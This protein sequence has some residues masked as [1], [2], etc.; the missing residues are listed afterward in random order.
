MTAR[1]IRPDRTRRPA[2]RKE[3]VDHEHHHADATVTI[4]LRAQVVGVE[5]RADQPPLGIYLFD[6][7]EHPLCHCTVLEDRT[8]VELPRRMLGRMVTAA[9]APVVAGRK[10]PTLDTLRTRGV[11]IVRVPLDSVRRGIDLGIVE[12]NPHV[13]KRSCCRVR[14]RV[15]RRITL[16]SGQ[17]IERPLCNARVVICEVDVSPRLI[18]ARLAD[19]LVRELATQ[20]RDVLPAP[21][22]TGPVTAAAADAHLH[23]AM[24]QHGHAG[25]DTGH[26]HTTLAPALQTRHVV[27]DDVANVRAHLVANIAVLNRHWCRFAALSQH[28]DVD[29]LKSVPLGPDGRFDTDISYFC[30]GDR[31]DLYFKVE[32]ACGDTWEVVHA[33][34]VACSTHW[35]YCCGDE[36]EILVTS[37]SAGLG[38]AF[39]PCVPASL[40][41]PAAI[42]QWQMLPYTSQVFVVHAGLLRTGQVLM[43]SGGVEGQLPKESRLWDPVT[44]G[45]ATHAFADDLFCAFQVLLPD[46][47]L[48]VMGGSNYNGPHGQGVTISYTF[49]PGAP[50]W[51]K[52]ADMAFARWYPTAVVLDNGR[53]VVASGRAAG[54]VVAQMESFNPA[55]NTWTTLPAS[56]NK[57][58]DIYPSLH[59][60]AG[61][62][63]FYSGTR[64][65]GGSSSPRPWP[66]PPDSALFDPTANT[67]ATVATHVIPNRTEGTSVLLPPRASAAHHHGHGEAM[68]PPGTLSRVLVLGGDCGS[69]AER[70]SAEVIDLADPAPHWQRIADMHHRRVNPNAVILA[71]GSVLVCAGITGFKWD[72]DPG[73]VLESEIFDPQG[74]TWRRAAVMSDGRQYHSISLLLPDGRVLNTGSVGG[75]GGGTNLT[76]MEIYS[77]PYLF[78]GPRPRITAYETSVA[79]GATLRI[80]T[81][82]ACRIRRAV[83]VRPGAPTH[84]TDTDQRYLPLDFSRDGRCDLHLQVPDGAGLLPP[85]YYL[86]FI[87]DDCDVPSVGKFVQVS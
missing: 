50:G 62:R 3:K 25:H 4:A 22:A 64:W 68:P 1:R 27:V 45:F 38:P 10:E 66:S 14:G 53:V 78:R 21:P 6:E 13:F 11:H 84:H 46:G 24:T 43:F 86:V 60:V 69:P 39:S 55:G 31:P 87:L 35:D 72:P 75:S 77:P 80:T 76:S 26:M 56:A 85:G 51:V 74:L 82:D 59:L 41:D 15:V 5:A 16:P 61:G 44:G 33:P 81:P 58:L 71:D 29:C 49:D 19:D 40:T 48:L 12:I 65:E 34:S 83:L 36:V 17:V 54:P 42:G 67:W 37:T 23:V 70:V 7:D 8:T 20:A 32:Q 63:V 52:H 79:R 28:Y 18:I 57:A 30:Y 47:R 2:P 73:R 9:V